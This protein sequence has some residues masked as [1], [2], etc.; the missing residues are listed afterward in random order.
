MGGVVGGWDPKQQAQINSV[1]AMFETSD[2]CYQS[3][4][5]LLIGE[6]NRR[7][8]TWAHMTLATKSIKPHGL[9]KTRAGGLNQF[10]TLLSSY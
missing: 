4:G 2:Y 1:K 6:A 10:Q 5:I 8:L 7:V 3:K 9:I